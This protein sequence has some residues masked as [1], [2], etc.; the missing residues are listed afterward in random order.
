VREVTLAP[1]LVGKH[2]LTQAQWLR[3]AGGNPSF[4][5]AGG[6]WAGRTVTGMHPVEQ[7]S[8]E[9]AM[10]VLGR[11]DLDLPTEAQWEYATRAGSDAPWWPGPEVEYLDG[12]ANLADSYATSQ[13]APWPAEEWLDDGFLLHA[14]VGSFL[15]N[16]FGL[17]DVHGNVLEWCRDLFGEYTLPVEPGTGERRAEGRART[18]RGGSFN[19]PAD[20]ARSANRLY[21]PPDA[22]DFS[23]GLRPAR[24]LLPAPR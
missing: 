5:S 19:F 8:W 24:G 21:H 7:V 15:A 11:F 2:E 22:R 13:G 17:H 3:L 18:Y 4:Y 16:A 14:P 10:R 6:T 9:H 23:L 1:F 12:V 20:F